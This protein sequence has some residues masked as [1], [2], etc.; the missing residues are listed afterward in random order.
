MTHCLNPATAKRAE[1]VAVTRRPAGR[2]DADADDAG[3]A[4]GDGGILGRLVNRGYQG[5]I[6]SLAR[7]NE[8]LR[9]TLKRLRE[10]V[11]EAVRSSKLANSI[12]GRSRQQG[13]AGEAASAA[14]DDRQ[15][16]KQEDKQ[17]E[18][19]EG[20]GL[21]EMPFAMV[22]E[23]IEMDIAR[24]I[25]Q[26][27][28]HTQKVIHHPPPPPTTAT[29]TTSAAAPGR[30]AE[31]EA[32][33]RQQDALLELALSTPLDPLGLPLWRVEAEA[34]ADERVVEELGRV[35]ASRAALERERQQLTNAMIVF[36]QER[37][38]LAQ[39]KKRIEAAEKARQAQVAAAPTPKRLRS[40]LG[41]LSP[42][43]DGKRTR[44]STAATDTTP[45][46]S[47]L[48]LGTPVQNEKENALNL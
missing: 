16:D 11:A 39:E 2:G 31:L 35:E 9:G 12:A 18:T 1:G 36:D 32:L 25:A 44:Q 41:L 20:E 14:A 4:D 10:E 40:A 27:R 13:A 7:E 38:A 48:A 23:E 33:L 37:A 22:K 28:E 15:E 43:P 30:I 21:F 6:A 47:K 42:T 24:Q 5:Q 46:F 3:D 19:A 34:R 8:E 29:T 26:L 17:E 45:G